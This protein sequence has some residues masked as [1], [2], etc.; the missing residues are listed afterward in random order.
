[1]N[2]ENMDDNWVQF[3]GNVNERWDN[4]TERDMAG[5]VQDTYG[6]PNRDDDM[7]LQLTDWQQRLGEIE[8]AAQLKRRADAVLAGLALRGA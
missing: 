3:S 1:M 4:R 7:Q 2:W 6:M 8:R 5:R